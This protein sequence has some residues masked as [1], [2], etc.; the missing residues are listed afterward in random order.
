MTV[1]IAPME[2]WMR[3]AGRFRPQHRPV[4]AEA[5]T[6]D[7]V[8][9]ALALFDELDPQSQDWYGGARFVQS[10]NERLTP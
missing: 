9:L 3:A 2:P 6:R 10:L 4:F 1:Q 5:P 7:D 8:A